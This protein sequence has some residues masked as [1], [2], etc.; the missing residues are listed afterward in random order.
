M[1]VKKLKEYLDAHKIK[2]VTISHSPGYTAREVAASAL[3]PR[4]EFAKTVMVTVDNNMAM[5]VIPAS[6]RLDLERFALLIQAKK[7][8]LADEQEF[9]DRFPD[10]EVGAM[11]P[12]G[13]LYDMEVYVAA[14]LTLDDEIVFN[15]GSHTQVIQM[16]Y[17]DYADLVQPKVLDIAVKH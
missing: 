6:R 17:E 3:V 16:T 13:N 4:A 10:C 9:Q 11:P 7:V 1:P 2:Y 12:F 8:K 14:N 5:V 15:A